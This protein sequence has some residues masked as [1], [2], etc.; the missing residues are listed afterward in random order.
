[1]FPL[2]ETRGSEGQTRGVDGTRAVTRASA[3][4]PPSLYTCTLQNGFY[5]RGSVAVGGWGLPSDHL[6]A[7]LHEI[8]LSNSN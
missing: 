2:T 4:H 6:R 7:C 1:M 3:F 5:P 8:G